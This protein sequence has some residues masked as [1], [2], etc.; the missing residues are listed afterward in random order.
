[1]VLR[2]ELINRISQIKS[3]IKLND[4][5]LI[6]ASRKLDFKGLTIKKQFELGS[7]KTVHKSFRRRK[8][9]ERRQASF[10]TELFNNQNLGFREDLQAAEDDLFVFDNIKIGEGIL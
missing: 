3:S 2:P 4:V 7:S 6:D 9:A 10:D 8:K 1:M 5:K